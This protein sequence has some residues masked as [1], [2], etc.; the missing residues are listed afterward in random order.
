[1][2][3]LG[4]MNL[5]GKSQENQNYLHIFNLFILLL[6]LRFGTSHFVLQFSLRTKAEK[7]SINSV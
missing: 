4:K 3:I 6:I 5:K 7:M 2:S 1:M